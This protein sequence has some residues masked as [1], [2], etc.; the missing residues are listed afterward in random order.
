[1]RASMAIKRS[2]GTGPRSVATTAVFVLASL[3]TPIP[4]L[5]IDPTFP[6]DEAW[7]PLTRSGATI[8]DAPLDTTDP[9][10]DLVGQAEPAAYVTS[11]AAFLFA[12]L[13][14]DGSPGVVGVGFDPQGWVIELDTDANTG[15]GFELLA[16]VNGADETVELWSLAGTGAISEQATNLVA[17]YP[18]ATHARWLLDGT[19]DF[20]V[21]FAVPRS[22]LGAFPNPLQ[23]VAGATA[24]AVPRVATGN[25]ADIA[26]PTPVDPSTFAAW[27]SDPLICD[28]SG[29]GT[30]APPPPPVA[31]ADLALSLT[32]PKASA[33]GHTARYRFS[34]SNLGPDPASGVSA[35]M[36]LPAGL[37]L[38][39]AG[40]S[41]WVCIGGNG[42]V[43]CTR[44]ADL[45]TGASVKLTVE[46]TVTAPRGSTLV[47]RGNVVASTND[48]FSSNDS[49]TISTRV[50]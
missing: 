4:A 35:E 1:M 36:N 8:G 29:C 42:T 28:D 27:A 44:A 39:S 14:V 34:V 49:A 2:M 16:M 38:V 3:V 40:G 24:G 50:R 37:A 20:F 41:G 15:N 10:R 46:A 43:S 26:G 19:A 7:T 6:P 18:A 32:G 22:D 11:D 30:T 9:A 17:T 31:T 25:S 48:G 47:I 13:R 33:P 5:A 23:L 45:A 21:D 12:R